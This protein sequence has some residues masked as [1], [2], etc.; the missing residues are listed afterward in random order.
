M[1]SDQKKEILK[2]PNYK[3][4]V[5]FYDCEG[6]G[7]CIKACPEQAIEAGPD[8]LPA[9]V[10]LSDGKYEMLPGR[11]VII[12]DKCTGCADCIPVCPNQALEMVPV[13]EANG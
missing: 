13:S 2:G 10:C 9:A 6:S 5:K 11:A 3:A 8:R 4:Q 12:E 7:E 1:M